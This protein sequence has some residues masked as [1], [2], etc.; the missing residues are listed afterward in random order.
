MSIFRRPLNHTDHAK[1]FGNRIGVRVSVPFDQAAFVTVRPYCH[2]FALARRRVENLCG[3][4]RVSQKGAWVKLRLRQGRNN[5]YISKINRKSQ[6]WSLENPSH[7]MRTGGGRG[8]KRGQ[9][10]S[11]SCDGRTGWGKRR[12]LLSSNRLPHSRPRSLHRL[13]PERSCEAER[14]VRQES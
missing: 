5:K 2:R 1:M 13:L 8:W 4:G 6:F 14:A 12:G 7:H 3:A 9:L 11:A 10:A